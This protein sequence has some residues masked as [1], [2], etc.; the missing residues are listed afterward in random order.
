MLRNYLRIAW[1]NITRQKVYSAINVVG[2]AFGICAC[3]VIYLV[4]SYDFS[5][6]RFHPDK[7]RI[8]RIVAQL[9]R[10][11]GKKDFRTGF[12]SD[13]ADFERSIP[14]F[15]AA[16]GFHPYSGNIYIPSNGIGPGRKF[17]G[18]IRR[19]REASIITGPQYFDIFRYR[20]L[21]GDPKTALA[22]PFKVVLTESTARKYFGDVPLDK[23]VGRTIIYDDSLTVS[24]SGIVED[25][26][27]RTNFGFQNF[28][29][30]S[31]AASSFLKKEIPTA[32][33]NGK[34][35]QSFV[36]L[37]KG[38][39]AADIDDRLARF[40]KTHATKH[41]TAAK[42]SVWLQPLTS[43]HFTNDYHR[44]DDGDPFYKPYL[45]T[46]YS[47]MGLAFFIL[48][49]A[50][51]NFV[52]L[53]TA[54][55]LRRAKEVG[56]RK[57]MGGK[58]SDLT[59]QFLT[60]TAVLVIFAVFISLLMAKPVISAFS[61]FLPENFEFHF[62]DL[63]TIGILFII[64]VVTIL[65]AGFYPARVL[66]SLLPVWTLKGRVMEQGRGGWNIR[67]G[68]IV[69]QFTISLVFIIGAIVIGNQ[70]HFMRTTDK[71]FESEAIVTLRHWGDRT[72]KLEVLAD[73][74]KKIPGVEQVIFEGDPPMGRAHEDDKFTYKAKQAIELTVFAETTNEE[75]IPFY[76]MKLIAGRNITHSDSLSELVINETC[77]R[78]M[79]FTNP[80]DAVGKFLYRGTSPYPIVGV[81]ADFYE[82]SFHDAIRPDVIEHVP[83]RETGLGI[84]L[85]TTVKE[86]HEVKNIISRIGEVWKQIYPEDLFHPRFVDE[87]IERLF[88]EDETI[89]WLMNV[90]MA[91]T[92]FI[93]CMGLFGIALFSAERRS[94][95]ISIRRVL[96]AKITA[97]IT[98]LTKDILVLILIA[99]AIATPIAWYFM[100][101]WLKD[102][103][104]RVPIG[105]WVFPLAGAIALLIAV[106]TIG[107]QAIKAALANPVKNLRTE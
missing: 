80:G 60:E 49:I 18:V 91:I 11:D 106:L 68:L 34:G 88:Q 41:S 101:Q 35:L 38:V 43:I 36:K 89:A 64:S 14:G 67:K 97:I 82:I 69:F 92:I 76:H 103:V 9:Q 58:R 90:A 54:Q 72:G 99:V 98:L 87:D 21:T 93:S 63:A 23:I 102:F 24:V 62:F 12:L 107:S 13:V 81:V 77:A 22:E 96:G 6:D 65:L 105:W 42:L 5:F 74:V 28:I 20:W 2:L 79:G 55:S 7:D 16:A 95:E 45:P 104:Y 52:N 47:L 1:R 78:A 19:G 39:T 8:F 10:E 27:G 71:G 26:N 31:T 32:D 50:A 86:A 30:I 100:E 44:R 57:V 70:L 17:D 4:T 94:K 51:V 37:E 61:S 29:S 3:L 56:V 84:K 33:W 25:W 75:F 40:I 15:E 48:I 66:A 83:Q 85:A 53:S 73:R 59:F 46:L